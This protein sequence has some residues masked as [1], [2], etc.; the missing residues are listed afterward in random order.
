M[1]S[2]T[3]NKHRDSDDGRQGEHQN[4]AWHS[5]GTKAARARTRFA[6]AFGNAGGFDRRRKSGSAATM[7]RGGAQ[8][9]GGTGLDF[10]VQPARRELTWRKRRDVR[11]NR[12]GY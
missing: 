4:P 5:N 11:Q 12:R 9:V 2:S 10:E 3:G 7:D 1:G 6:A 8:V